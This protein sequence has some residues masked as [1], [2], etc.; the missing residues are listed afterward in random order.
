MNPIT[1][2]SNLITD[3]RL[4][5]DQYVDIFS[6]QYSFQAG[7]FFLT[8]LVFL[9]YSRSVKFDQNRFF[10]NYWVL[11]SIY[12]IGA[13]L[14]LQS[15]INSQFDIP[16]QLTSTISQF[17]RYLS[18]CFFTMGMS[19]LFL[20]Q[21]FQRRT[22][23][24]VTG[25]CAIAALGFQIAL[26]YPS[27]IQDRFFWKVAPPSFIG[28]VLYFAVGFYFCPCLNKRFKSKRSFLPNYS[29]NIP[30]LGYGLT[31]VLFTIIF[32]HEWTSET[33]HIN[34]NI[35]IILIS[36]QIVLQ[37]LIGIG[38][39]K[40]GL[41]QEQARSKKLNEHLLKSENYGIVGQLSAGLVHDFNNVMTIFTCSTEMA[42]NGY[43][44]GLNI[45]NYLDKILETAKKATDLN[46]KLL[47]I[48]QQNKNNTK[49]HIQFSPKTV[50]RDLAPILDSALPNDVKLK[51]NYK[52][53]RDLTIKG[54]VSELEMVLVNLVINARDSFSGLQRRSIQNKITLTAES[55]SNNKHIIIQVRDNGSGMKPE[56]LKNAREFGFSTKGNKGSGLGL[57]NAQ[58]FA[59]EHWGTL[60]IQSVSSQTHDRGTVITIQLPTV[61]EK[62]IEK[63]SK[64]HSISVL[65]DDPKLL[66]NCQS[67]DWDIQEINAE[68]HEIVDRTHDLDVLIIDSES[69]LQK[70]RADQIIQEQSLSQFK[71]LQIRND[72]SE[73]SYLTWDFSYE[74]ID[75]K[76]SKGE[77]HAVIRKLIQENRSYTIRDLIYE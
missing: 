54:S 33:I 56:V 31:H 59:E 19:E 49:D 35:G 67:P 27:I 3:I 14:A 64:P 53:L 75:K 1:S 48:S 25:L 38:L 6:V 21:R 36:I 9:G 52:N 71:V 68:D 26:A 12:H 8:A 51:C 15:L 40:L 43:Q 23:L 30:I 61:P 57:A 50:I 18:F 32:T 24:I 44:Q 7:I 29:L 11:L 47:N 10:T 60:D 76:H 62:K 70:S 72:P 39:F 66:K 28:S 69:D 42:K 13:F 17:S 20:E 37:Y 77:L 2:I 65:S 73:I 58:R 16:H 55:H 41:L 4:T 34:Y 45:Q 5:P 74:T 22:I 63:S 46:S